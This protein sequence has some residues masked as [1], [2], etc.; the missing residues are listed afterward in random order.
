MAFA[1]ARL[2]TRRAHNHLVALEK[3][4]QRFVDSEPYAIYSEKDPPAREH[5]VFLKVLKP[6]RLE[7]WAIVAGDVLHNL[8]SALDHIVWELAIRHLGKPP[9]PLE[10]DWKRLAFPIF[11]EKCVYLYGPDKKATKKILRG[12]GLDQIRSVDPAFQ[13]LFKSL[14]PFRDG[15]KRDRNP[16]QVLHELELIDK[17]RALPVLLSVVV[18]MGATITPTPISGIVGA[19]LEP[20]EIFTPGP[21]KDGTPLARVKETGSAHIT[22]YGLSVHMYP[23]LSFRVKLKERRPTMGL[24]L[25]PTLGAM[26]ERVNEIIDLFQAK[27]ASLPGA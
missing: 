6:P 14:Q 20:V 13:A 27:L 21:F 11:R 24:P 12:S 2:K 3:R 10:R 4:V 15:P 17:H 23:Q 19:A 7:D 25:L 8:R 5:I 26:H 18:P 1:G 22:P 16:L 9:Y